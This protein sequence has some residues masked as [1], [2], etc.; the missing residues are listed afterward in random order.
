MTI[1]FSKFRNL[2]NIQIPTGDEA[3]YY[4]NLAKK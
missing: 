4:I 2:C 1:I 3:Y